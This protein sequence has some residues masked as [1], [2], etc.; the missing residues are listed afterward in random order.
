VSPIGGRGA[1][2]LRGSKLPMVLAVT[3]RCGEEYEVSETAIDLAKCPNR[4]CRLP[5][6]DFPAS[7]IK[8]AKSP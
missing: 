6:R 1:R 4:T 2:R 5:T 8:P 7:R 3:C